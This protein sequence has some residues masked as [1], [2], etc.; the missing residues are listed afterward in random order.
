ML[1]RSPVRDA[2]CP[3]TIHAGED[4]GPDNIWQAIEDLGAQRIGHGIRCVDDPKLMTYLREKQIC[5]EICPTSNWV[6]QAV[7][8]LEKHPLPTILRAG[9]PV[10]INTDDPG[11]FGTTLPEEYRLCTEIIGLSGAE[12][13][14]CRTAAARYSFLQ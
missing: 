14:F 8:S 10:S 1:F 6:T 9:I 7:P 11:V 12:L 2:G 4:A 5:L 13:D 3:I